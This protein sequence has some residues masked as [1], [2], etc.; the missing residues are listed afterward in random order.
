MFKW[1]RKLFNRY[2]DIRPIWGIRLASHDE[3]LYK[4][5]ITIFLGTYI[6]SF[7]LPFNI[8]KPI[9]D[10]YVYKKDIND[11][12]MNDIMATAYSV[13]IYGITYLPDDGCIEFNWNYA[14]DMYTNVTNH[15]GTMKLIYLFW[16]YKTKVKTILL[17]LDSTPFSDITDSTNDNIEY[18]TTLQPRYFIKVANNEQVAVD[19]ECRAV[20]T[21]YT[22]GGSL[23]TKLIMSI[24]KK[25]IVI[26]RLH[27]EIPEDDYSA[28]LNIHDDET[29]LDAFKRFCLTHRYVFISVIDK[30]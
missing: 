28:S 18:L 25:P 3:I 7:I 21:V 24:F 6:K 12:D 8:I 16:R 2:A 15:I 30:G 29:I 14:D 13:N 1:F 9:V 11:N 23:I 19:A 26:R 17:N 27:I 20:L 4:N 10:Y 5:V 22:Y